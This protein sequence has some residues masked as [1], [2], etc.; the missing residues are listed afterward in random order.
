MH[1]S[2]WR[3]AAVVQVFYNGVILRQIGP[4]VH[5]DTTVKV[6]PALVY[7]QP[8]GNGVRRILLLS[9]DLSWILC[10]ALWP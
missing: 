3:K 5:P 10:H 9:Y 6:L 4:F 1:R 2:I 7:R 8:S